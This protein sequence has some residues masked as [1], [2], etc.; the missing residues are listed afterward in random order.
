MKIALGF[1]IK[2][3]SFLS[4]VSGLW[5]QAP[6]VIDVGVRGGAFGTAP[7]IEA[8]SNH[9]FPPLYTV[10]RNTFSIGP[11]IGALLYNR[12]EIRFEAVRS[13]FEFHGTSITGPVSAT[14][15][16]RG[17]LWQYPLLATY[18]LGSGPA[19]PF[20]GGGLSL[21]SSASGTTEGT[22]TVR[23]P[24]NPPQTNSLNRPY[25]T[26]SKPTA[27][28]ISGG[29]DARTKLFSIRPELRYARWSQFSDQENQ[30]LNGRNQFEFV[31]GVS[32]QAFRAK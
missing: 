15:T 1:L 24:P 32:L 16:T 5:A 14:W 29:I 3:G 17:H 31:I 9:Y 23:L 30:T 21:K 13:Q 7:P 8:E 18:L 19:R 12:L 25:R 26:F 6:L 4:V 28:Y 10:D 2:V 20:A 11:S 22:Q 27:Y